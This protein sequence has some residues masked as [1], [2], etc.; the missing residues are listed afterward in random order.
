M[1]DYDIGAA[2]RAIEDELI[3]SMIR[4]MKRHRIDEIENEKQWEMWQAKQLES[5]EQYKKKNRKKYK[6][7]FGSINDSIDKILRQAYEEGGMEQEIEMLQAIKKR[8]GDNIPNNIRRM[9]DNLTQKLPFGRKTQK[10]FFQVDDKRLNAL[11]HATTSDMQ[12]AEA[13]MLRLA[14]DQYRRNIFNAHTY[15]ISGAGTYEK[16]VDMATRDFLA[17]GI[18][19]IEYKNGRRVNIKSYAEMAIRTASKRAQLYADGE[20]RKAMGISTVIVKK[21]LNACPLCLPFVDK[22]LIDD[23]WSA[24]KQSD[25][26]YPLVSAALKAGFLHPNCEDHLSTY[27]PGITEPPDDEFTEDEIKQV[28]QSAAADAENQYAVRQAEKFGRLA[29]YSLDGENLKQYKRR[30]EQW[31]TVAKA[32][33][34]GILKLSDREQAA[35]NKYISS[36]SYTLND[37]LRRNES[38]SS[39]DETLIKDLDDAL[40]KMPD[41]NGTVRRSVSDFGIYDVDEFVKSHV[42]GEQYVSP[43]Y[44]SSSETVYDESFPIQ[45]VI[46]SKHGKDI[47][48]YNPGEKEILFKRDTKFW[49]TKIDGNTIYMEEA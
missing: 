25:G 49:I 26:P 13:A 47:R 10:D 36:E 38:L 41:Y 18:N 22:I 31:K 43:A 4:N 5:L 16:A 1:N 3:A 40:D 45:Y 28:R 48:A 37:M 39:V 15:A 14:D 6:D 17:A 20:T 35:L 9:K 46:R 32:Q 29:K 8:Y 7:Q 11:V 30:E 23:V 21:R 12:T 19:C 33:E 2:F 34:S 42:V 27:I 44:I 24:G